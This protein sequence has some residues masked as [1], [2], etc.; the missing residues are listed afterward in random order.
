MIRRYCIL[1]SSIYAFSTLFFSCSAIKS[2]VLANEIVRDIFY[3]MPSHTIAHGAM[4][5]NNTL[6][7]HA[8]DSEILG[9]R[10]CK[11]Y[12]P[13]MHAL[14]HLDHY[15]E[16]T[17]HIKPAC[18]QIVIGERP[19][20]DQK[21]IKSKKIKMYDFNQ[22]I[23]QSSTGENLKN[24]LAL[25]FSGNAYY[26]MKGES[27]HIL[28]EWL[29]SMDLPKLHTLNLSDNDIGDVSVALLAE[30]ITKKCFNKL[31]LLDLS[32]NKIQDPGAIELAKAHFNKHMVLNLSGNHIESDGAQA[33]VQATD[34]ETFV[35]FSNLNLTRNNV[36]DIVV[37]EIVNRTC[38]TKSPKLDL[39][40]NK[41]FKSGNR[42]IQL[43]KNNN[44]LLLTE[45]YLGDNDAPNVV[46]DNL[47]SANLSN[48]LMLDLSYN[49]L[50]A[51]DIQKLRY[52]NFQ[53]VTT[54][55]L[56]G[57]PIG[58]K[59]IQALVGAHG[60]G[61]SLPNIV[62]LDLSKTKM[63]SGGAKILAMASKN[64]YKSIQ[65]NPNSIQPNH[66]DVRS[67]FQK[68]ERLLLIGNAIR[69]E[70]ALSLVNANLPSIASVDLSCNNIMEEVTKMLEQDKRQC[71]VLLNQHG[72]TRDKGFS[73]RILLGDLSRL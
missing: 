21:Y 24:I 39:T 31:M 5:A 16:S 9:R 70:G 68:L 60:V 63:G 3:S 33:L 28:A 30:V 56:C 7:A 67:T 26:S 38:N 62:E 14:Y 51:A 18:L 4:E 69:D 44:C 19:K 58:N 55:K 64:S 65:P 43:F 50:K 11:I 27:A 37:Q 40:G 22:P 36:G 17:E 42:P 49:N 2:R 52:K 8:E 34:R 23:P 73:T 54:F 15:I 66:A 20:T 32:N 47:N 72:G 29:A 35:A 1:L 59:G 46:V 13:D 6:R 10:W 61:G 12:I 45:L 53:K 48:L 25:D 57:N 41:V 71:F